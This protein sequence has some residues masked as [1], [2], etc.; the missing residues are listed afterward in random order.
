MGAA[1]RMDEVPYLKYAFFSYLWL[2]VTDTVHHLHAATV[3]GQGAAMHAAA[4]GMV[5]VPTAVAMVA[6]YLRFG[7]R[8]LLWTFLGI[9]LLAIAVPG[10]YHGGWNHLVKV[11]AHLRIDS[12]ATDLSLLFPA[13]NLNLWFYEV[14]G[15]FEFVFAIVCGYF[16]YR[17]VTVRTGDT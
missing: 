1:D 9:A 3:L 15:L 16:V 12:P 2:G 4:I 11:L 17:L 7:R 6:L 5:L 10:L 8:A 14:T 13:D